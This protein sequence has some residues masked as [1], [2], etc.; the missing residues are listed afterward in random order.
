MTPTDA[1]ADPAAVQRLQRTVD[2]LPVVHLEGDGAPPAPAWIDVEG[3][4]ERPG[5]FTVEDLRA[6]DDRFMIADHHCVWGWSKRTCRWRG[7]MLGALLDHVGLLPGATHVTVVC[8]RSAYASCMETAD[9]R[10]GILAWGLDGAPLPPE[11]GAPIR[12][13]NA[14]RLWGYK[15][16]K[17]AGRIVVGDEATPG[18]WEEMVGDPRGHVPEPVL[19]QFG[20]WRSRWWR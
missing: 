18:F 7:A 12:F 3:M 17:W 13:Q 4:V 5:R 16:V 8:H 10:D 15:G 11:H 2:R 19:R 6:I 20:Y 1:T 9:A 14:E